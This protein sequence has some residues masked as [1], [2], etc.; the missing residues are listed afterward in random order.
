MLR[1]RVEVVSE[2]QLQVHCQVT[3]VWTYVLDL[4]SDTEFIRTC[5]YAY[6]QHVVEVELACFASSCFLLC[7][8]LHCYYTHCSCRLCSWLCTVLSLLLLF[9]FLA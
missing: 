5:V 1:K 9:L 7:W 6:L 3:K 2:I 4:S 8:C